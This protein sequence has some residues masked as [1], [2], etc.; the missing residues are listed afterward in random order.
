LNK[1]SYI[2][3]I[4]LS[5]AVLLFAIPL[6]VY[7]FVGANGSVSKVFLPMVIDS[8]PATPPFPTPVP[9][10]YIANPGFE[11]GQTGWT[12]NWDTPNPV[13][14]SQQAHAG[15][16]SAMLGDGDAVY[17]N[18]IQASITQNV[19]VP[20]VEYVLKFW[21]FTQSTDECGSNPEDLIGDYL[22]VDIDN[23]TTWFI[24]VCDS[25]EN[26]SWVSRS[27]NLS[28]YQGKSIFL[29]VRYKSDLSLPS[30]AYVDDFAF[31]NP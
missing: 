29:T 12:F 27:I 3:L 7:A 15:T 31:A 9:S 4:F 21:T 22:I 26:G 20:T 18:G 24:P 2:L 23:V 6:A 25:V 11:Q 8:N 16:Y 1:R 17:G 13:I 30:Y 5:V 28:A 10:G 19:S 14:T